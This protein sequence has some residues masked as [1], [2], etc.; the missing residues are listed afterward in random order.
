MPY[1]YADHDDLIITTMYPEEGYDTRLR[2]LG[3]EPA[4]GLLFDADHIP[5]YPIDCW[6]YTE[7][8]ITWAMK[9]KILPLPRYAGRKKN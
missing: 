6:G 7:S 8:L 3:I 2:T 9:N 5:A 1:L 4:K